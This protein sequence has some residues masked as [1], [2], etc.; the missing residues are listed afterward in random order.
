MARTS[1]KQQKQSLSQLFSEPDKLYN[2]AIYARL[3]VEDNGKGSDYIESQIEYLEAFIANDP[4]MRKVAVFIDN[5][6]TGT[7]FMRPEFQRM[8]EAARHG[9]INC[10]VVKD[11]SR[12]GRNYVETGEFL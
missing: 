7:N 2:V 6:F 10:I 9:D 8:I 1:R 11:L 4:T 12:L 3:S 5:G